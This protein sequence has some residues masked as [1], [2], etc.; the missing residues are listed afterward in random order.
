VVYVKIGSE[1]LKFEFTGRSQGNWIDYSSKMNKAGKSLHKHITRFKVVEN[2]DGGFEAKFSSGAKVEDEEDV[3]NR[4][5][6]LLGILGSGNL[7]SQGET[8]KQLEAKQ[9]PLNDEEPLP[10]EPGED[11]TN[12]RNGEGEVEDVKIEDVPW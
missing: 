10:E 3:R 2:K 7:L 1:T 6:N 11:M 12:L 9:V 4:V 8:P 5:V